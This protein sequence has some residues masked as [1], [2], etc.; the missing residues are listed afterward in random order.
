LDASKA[1]QAAALSGG[2]L[3]VRV[4]DYR[5]VRDVKIR[6]GRVVLYGP[7]MAGKPAPWRY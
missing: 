7:N 3:V 6:T 2:E 5:G 1:G 4:R